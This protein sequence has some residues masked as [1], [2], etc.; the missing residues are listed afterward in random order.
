MYI[1]T[2]KKSINYILKVYSKN[3]LEMIRFGFFYFVFSA[4]AFSTENFYDLDYSKK[5]LIYINE[6]WVYTQIFKDTQNKIVQYKDKLVHLDGNKN[7]IVLALKDEEFVEAAVKKTEHRL[8]VF[9]YTNLKK[10][11]LQFIQKMEN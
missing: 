1:K 3:N 10:M 6:E 5:D 2:N 9:H 7:L 4:Y 8:E 11:F